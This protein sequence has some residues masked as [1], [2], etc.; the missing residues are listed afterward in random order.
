MVTDIQYVA[1]Q[2][3]PYMVA[4][5]GRL[6]YLGADLVDLVSINTKRDELG[7]KVWLL[8]DDKCQFKERY[9]ILAREK[10]VAKDQ[11][12]AWMGSWSICR[13]KCEMW[14]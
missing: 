8:E 9:V 5:A 10:G 13:N 14:W 6:C 2:V 1:A 4:A 3:A 11:V 7:E 12:L